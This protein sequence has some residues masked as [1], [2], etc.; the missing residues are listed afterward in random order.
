M[1]QPLRTIIVVIALMLP[2]AGGAQCNPMSYSDLP[3]TENFNSYTP[4]TTF[5]NPCWHVLGTYSLAANIYQTTQPDGTTGPVLRMEANHYHMSGQ[6]LVLPPVEDVHNVVISL[7]TK[8]TYY[9]AKLKVGVMTNPTDTSTFTLVGIFDTL[10]YSSWSH[11][12][13]HFSQ[14]SGS[15]QYIALRTVPTNFQSIW[16]Y[17]DDIVVSALECPAPRNLTVSDYVGGSVTLSWQM[18]GDDN[19]F[20]LDVPG[21]CTDT[22]SD[23][24]YT[25]TGLSPDH[26]YTVKLRTLCADTTSP[27]YTASF[28]TPVT[29][30]P[31][32]YSLSFDG[33]TV[34]EGCMHLGNAG[35]RLDTANYVDAPA[36]LEFLASDTNNIFVLPQFT[37]EIANLCI[38]LF[39]RHS[40]DGSWGFGSL[41]V[42]YITDPFNP[43]TFVAIHSYNINNTYNPDFIHIHHTFAGAPVGSRIALRHYAETNYGRWEIDRIRVSGLACPPP[44]VLTPLRVGSNTATIRW[45]PAA[46]ADTWLVALNGDTVSVSDTFYTFIGL[47]ADTAYV[48]S[49]ARLCGSDTSGW[50]DAFFRTRCPLITSTDLPYIEDFNDYTPGYGRP[51]APCWARFEFRYGTSIPTNMSPS[52]EILEGNGILYVGYM[53][54]IR[55]Y[56]IMPEAESVGQLSLSFRTRTPNLDKKFIVGIMVDPWVLGTFTAIDSVTPTAADTWESWRIPLSAYDG[57]GGHVAICVK[58]LPNNWGFTQS[59]LR[60]YIDDI[61]LADTSWTPQDTTVV[62]PDT[63]MGVYAIDGRNVKIYSRD[64]S[65]VVECNDA[66]RIEIRDAMGRLVAV[67]RECKGSHRIPVPAAGAY[68]VSVGDAPARRIVVTR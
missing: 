27:V 66:E 6:W 50:V 11:V 34:S 58:G 53:S 43:T 24:S 47:N 44:L 3:F 12:E 52:P 7:Q 39:V 35:L 61:I 17:I 28:Q 2:V 23:T 5:Q 60:G 48:A 68:L 25:L 36:S 18:D 31:V 38:D 59:F 10:S 22:V 65:I 4:N 9:G 45:E 63:N 54:A 20:I 49:V 16:V 1:K 32:P 21:V 62:P 55:E 40:A 56:V 15:G 37:S 64:G 19:Q 13:Y 51:I 57:L 33:V 14:Y 26:E 67:R 46:G 30:L 8:M 29:V 41:Q 42:G